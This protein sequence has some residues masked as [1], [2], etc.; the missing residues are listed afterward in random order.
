MQAA[1]SIAMFYWLFVLSAQAA[2]QNG[3]FTVTWAPPTE[4]DP[5]LVYE[6]RWRSFANGTWQP[7]P[8]QD[9]RAMRFA[10]TFPPLP[11]TPATDRWLCVDARSKLGDQIGP[12][13]S[14]T[15]TGAACNTVEVGTVILPP[16]PPPIVPPP[17]VPPPVQP[18]PASPL[19]AVTVKGNDL[20]FDYKLA[21][22]PKGIQMKSGKIINGSRTVTMTCRK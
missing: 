8:D 16:P 9:S 1:L 18:P 7:L 14:E 20:T 17:V 5:R 3:S 19:T 22:C 10:H 4:T 6:F 11:A 2:V 21:A 13:L 12:W 15:A